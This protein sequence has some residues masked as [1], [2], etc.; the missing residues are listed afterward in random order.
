MDGCA[1][2][3]ACANTEFVYRRAIPALL[4]T[5]IPPLSVT[6]RATDSLRSAVREALDPIRMGV[7]EMANLPFDLDTLRQHRRQANPPHP[8][9]G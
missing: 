8:H 6:P 4:S 1:C 3:C 5:F 7:S 2:W 9:T